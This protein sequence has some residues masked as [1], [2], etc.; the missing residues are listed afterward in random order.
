MRL[1]PEHITKLR[2]AISVGDDGR[3]QVDIDIAHLSACMQRLS[4]WEGGLLV[5]A[6]MRAASASKLTKD[7]RV[8]LSMFVHD[9]SRRSSYAD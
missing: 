1:D 8:I 7:Q 4:L 2:S 5:E 6:L 9:H 3:G